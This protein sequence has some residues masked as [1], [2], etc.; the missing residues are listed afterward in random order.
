MIKAVIFDLGS[1]L[2]TE[3]WLAVYEKMANE[4]K[5]D[6]G[7]TK[8]IVKPLFD[9]LG[10]GEISEQIFW[11]EVEAQTGVELSEEFT[12]NFWFKTYKE[13][14][15]DIKESWEILIELHKRGIRLAVLANII[16]TSLLA[17]KEMG[18]LQRLRDVGVETF[19][20]SCE[21]GIKKPDL[22]IYEIAL[23]R[24]NLLPGACVFVDDKRVNIE[25]AEKL[26]I[27]GIVFQTPEQLREELIKLGLLLSNKF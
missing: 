9:K 19:I 4:L 15:K 27:R 11:K 20:A 12:E 13:W 16:K 6:V 18:R 26:G 23:K 10:K 25:A 21:E 7:K 8:E 14:S 2:T 24:L 17:N 5:I 3:D 1:V 22:K